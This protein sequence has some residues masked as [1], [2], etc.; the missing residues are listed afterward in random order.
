V[1]AAENLRLQQLRK[2]LEITSDDKPLLMDFSI[3]KKRHG[4]PR[5]EK[6]ELMKMVER[7][8]MQK[9]QSR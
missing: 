3:T 9:K 2:E 1:E 4:L 7:E 6:D 5:R 8:M